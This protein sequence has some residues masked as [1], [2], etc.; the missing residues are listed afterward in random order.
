MAI[1]DQMQAAHAEWRD[2]FE[3]G[4]SRL[5]WESLPPQVGDVAPDVELLDLDGSSRRLSEFWTDRPALILFWRHQSCSCGYDRAERLQREY[6]QYTG[7]G[8]NVVVVGQ[9]EPERAKE[10]A[11]VRS[12]PCPILCDPSYEA[13]WAF[14]LREGS[15]AQVIYDAPEEYWAREPA[16]WEGLI[17]NRDNEGRPFV[18]HPWLLPGEFVVGTD[19]LLR[20][21]YHY[22]YCENYP[23]PL[24]HVAAIKMAT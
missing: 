20:L 4:P 21:A 14:G 24:V 7:A 23:D 1:Q 19:G 10:Y 18:D 2:H 13:Y 9:A 22:Q 16:V 12:I 8:A 11:T 5:R 17:E 15:V 6:E 3:R